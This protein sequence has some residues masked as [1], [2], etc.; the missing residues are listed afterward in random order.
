[1]RRRRGKREEEKEEEEDD[2][3][4]GRALVENEDPTHRLGKRCPTMSSMSES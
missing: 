4:D 3:E 1:M 2:E